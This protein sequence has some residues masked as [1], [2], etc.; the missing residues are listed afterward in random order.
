LILSLLSPKRV[1][2]IQ[3]LC[4]KESA[5]HLSSKAIRQR[6]TIASSTASISA[7]VRLQSRTIATYIP[8]LDLPGRRE[9]LVGLAH[10]EMLAR[11]SVDMIDEARQITTGLRSIVDLKIGQHSLQL[12]IEAGLDALRRLLGFTGSGIAPACCMLHSPLSQALSPWFARRLLCACRAASYRQSLL[13]VT[14]QR[15]RPSPERTRC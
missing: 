1:R 5:F 13:R 11:L 14:G 8:Y 4:Y 2:S 6:V 15:R 9:E 12:T 3:K 10:R 7:I